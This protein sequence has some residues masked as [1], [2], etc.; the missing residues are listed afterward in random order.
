ML[1]H[2]SKRAEPFEYVLLAQSI[3]PFRLNRSA[4]ATSVAVSVFSVEESSLDNLRTGSAGAAGRS[5]SIQPTS[6]W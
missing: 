5:D 3:Y 4:D 1:G 6:F 2:E